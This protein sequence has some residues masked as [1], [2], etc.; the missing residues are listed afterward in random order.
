MKHKAS[1]TEENVVVH[2]YTFLITDYESMNKLS[3]QHANI[4]EQ[5]SSSCYKDV[6]SKS[7]PSKKN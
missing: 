5:R 1:Y 3:I 6:N 4:C 7:E 2:D